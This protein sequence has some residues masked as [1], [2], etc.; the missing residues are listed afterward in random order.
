M[1][2]QLSWIVKNHWSMKLSW[3]RNSWS[4]PQSSLKELLL[5]SRE[6]VCFVFVPSRYYTGHGSSAGHNG[7]HR[8]KLC[9][10]SSRNDYLSR[11]KLVSENFMEKRILGPSHQQSLDI[12][13]A[14]VSLSAR[15]V[16]LLDTSKLD[17]LM[18]VVLPIFWKI[19]NFFKENYGDQLKTWPGI[20]RP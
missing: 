1:I 10:G 3:T 6:V 20:S 13:T 2:W 18:L 7:F 5:C 4:M 17:C 14:Y 16:S 8:R 9:S 12:S 19:A 15:L 11:H